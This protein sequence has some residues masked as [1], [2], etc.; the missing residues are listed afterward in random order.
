MMP[1]EY[2]TKIRYRESYIFVY[3]IHKMSVEQIFLNT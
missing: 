1:F 2:M 3:L